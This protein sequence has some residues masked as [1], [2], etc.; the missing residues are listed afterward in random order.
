MLPS[1]VCSSSGSVRRP[2]RPMASCHKSVYGNNRTNHGMS[3][4]NG[5][6]W[7][8]RELRQIVADFRSGVKLLRKNMF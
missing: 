1:N 3:P 4:T 8:S 2:C 5:S 7:E 6:V